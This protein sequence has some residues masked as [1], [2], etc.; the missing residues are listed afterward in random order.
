MGLGVHSKQKQFKHPGRQQRNLKLGRTQGAVLGEKLGRVLRQVQ[1]HHQWDGFPEGRGISPTEGCT[2]WVRV[3]SLQAASW[4]VS[5]KIVMSFCWRLIAWA[6]PFVMFCLVLCIFLF[7]WE[8]MRMA[9]EK[10]NQVFLHRKIR[11][12]CRFQSRVAQKHCCWSTRHLLWP[13]CLSLSLV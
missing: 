1:S 3:E 13:L 8:E 2:Q 4:L 9:K 7:S 11:C 12:D 6:I 10:R 5:R